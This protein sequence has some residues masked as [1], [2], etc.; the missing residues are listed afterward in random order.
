MAKRIIPFGPVQGHTCDGCYYTVHSPA[1][2]HICLD[3]SG[4]FCEDCFNLT[5]Q[6][7]N[8]CRDKSP[9]K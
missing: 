6:R 1:Y 2:F 7:C 5:F 3:C 4:E 8:E 9:K